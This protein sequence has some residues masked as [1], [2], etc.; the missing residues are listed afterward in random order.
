MKLFYS[1]KTKIKIPRQLASIPIKNLILQID[2]LINW[3]LI[4]LIF[5]GHLRAAKQINSLLSFQFRGRIL[6]IYIY[7]HVVT[8]M[9]TMQTAS[10][11]LKFY[12]AADSLWISNC[13]I[14]L[15]CENIWGKNRG[16]VKVFLH[17]YIYLRAFF[18]CC[19]HFYPMLPNASSLWGRFL[20]LTEILFTAK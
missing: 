20:L 10:I 5:Q 11:V 17:L 15:H 12:K 18:V 14:I 7:T 13:S 8:F 6:Y 4:H 9:V 3:N 19:F 2:K 16:S 1:L